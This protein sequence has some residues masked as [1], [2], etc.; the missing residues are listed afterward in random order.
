[1]DGLFSIT[2]QSK[3]RKT[4]PIPV[5]T[6]PIQTCPSDC[7]LR[8]KGCMAEL[9]PLAIHWN[10]ISNELRGMSWDDLMWHIQRFRRNTLWRH[11]QAGDL[12]GEH[13]VSRT[14]LDDLIESAAH[15]A[16]IIY[17]HWDW[18]YNY[19]A[20]RDANDRG[21]PINVSANNV[22]DAVQAFKSGL[23]T[24]S[25]IPFDAPKHQE[26]DGVSIIEC[27]AY[28]NKHVN[29][30]TCGVCANPNRNSVIGFRPIGS[31][32]KSVNAIAVQNI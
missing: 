4:G 29:C 14:H 10:K 22:I 11:N 5:T 13:S 31:R 32:K 30:M 9:G 16:P 26:I 12:V 8:F 3:N 21:L 28:T 1:M 19:D 23:P 15:T 6:S 27:P 2:Y 7:A 25:L 20:F 24:V 18:R 17:S